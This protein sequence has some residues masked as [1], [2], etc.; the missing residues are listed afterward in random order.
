MLLD[1]RWNQKMVYSIVV[2][3]LVIMVLLLTAAV[4]CEFQ[5]GG[6]ALGRSQTLQTGHALSDR[7]LVLLLL[8]VHVV[9]VLAPL[10]LASADASHS[11]DTKAFLAAVRTDILLLFAP[12]SRVNGQS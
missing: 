7:H 8:H 11:V 1:H 6:H 4:W 10:V 2:H 5:T 3:L 9:Q 12:Q